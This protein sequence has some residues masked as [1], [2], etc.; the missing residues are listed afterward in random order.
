MDAYTK[1]SGLIRAISRLA[2]IIAM[3]V[4]FLTMLVLV[5]DIVLRLVTDSLAVTGSYELTEMA[6]V[7]IVF[8]GFA[9]T[10][11]EGEHVR[12]TML[13]DR[14]PGRAKAYANAFGSIFGTAV[15]AVVF[16]A[17]VRQAIGDSTSGI[18]TAVLFIP[19]APFA[20]IMALGLLLLTLALL[21]DSIDHVIRAVR[22]KP[23]PAVT[24]IPFGGE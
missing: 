24:G 16:Y 17:A 8:L 20:W 2:S 7:I 21:L 18:T 23:D 10:Q 15:C 11:V 3:A 22:N 12:V 19:T 13:V 4:A 6:M 1:I 9:I 5:A 14:L